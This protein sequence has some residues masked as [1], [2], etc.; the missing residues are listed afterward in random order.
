MRHPVPRKRF[1]QHFL[2]DP[3]VLERIVAAFSPSDHDCIIEIGPG[4]GALTKCLLA[5]VDSLTAIEMDRDLVKFLEKNHNPETLKVIQADALRLDF[6]SIHADRA[7][8]K[9]IRIIGNLPY[10]ISTPLLF[11]LLEFIDHIEDMVF[12]VQKEVALRLSA[13]PGGKNYGRLSVMSNL[14]LEC[15]CLFDVPPRAFYPPPKVQSTLVHLVPN[16]SRHPIDHPARFD[17]VVKNA[18][19][20]RRKTLRNS[21]ASLVTE[22]QFE[23][24]QVDPSLRAENLSPEQYIALSKT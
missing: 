19:S 18:F 14:A 4:T 7:A 8:A 22:K 9:K 16:P 10:N 13:R 2:K 5:R 11:H 6:S 21:L 3:A 1:G 20:Q 23:R 17:R 15:H 12:M 24:A